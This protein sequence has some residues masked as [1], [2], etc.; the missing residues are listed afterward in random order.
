[1]RT[2]VIIE[3]CG[4]GYICT[5]SGQFGGGYTGANAGPTADEAAARAARAM[6]HYAQGNKEGG[7]LVAPPEILDLI[8]SHLH[9]IGAK[10]ARTSLSAHDAIHQ[11]GEMA[12]ERLAARG[13]PAKEILEAGEKLEGIHDLHGE[14][15]DALALFW[16]GLFDSFLGAQKGVRI[17][18]NQSALAD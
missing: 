3:K 11:G 9:S 13:V 8:P 5:V 18:N 16:G 6:I 15:R 1:M 10:N 7:D 17:Q 12:G 4:A 2:T 14:I